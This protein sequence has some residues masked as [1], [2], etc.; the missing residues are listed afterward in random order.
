[1][2]F[3]LSKPPGLV[4]YDE[5]F[6][7]AVPWH[8]PDSSPVADIFSACTLLRHRGNPAKIIVDLVAFSAL[9][10]HPEIIR[11]ASL[12]LVEFDVVPFKL[13]EHLLK[14]LSG[15]HSFELRESLAYLPSRPQDESGCRIVLNTGV[16]HKS[17]NFQ[18][19]IWIL[20]DLL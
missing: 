19:R 1:M 5:L 16:N 4:T 7:C 20:A 9:C 15:C 10:V 12:D 14:E 6:T 3:T 17:T 2:E 18:G 11:R 8:R 13:I